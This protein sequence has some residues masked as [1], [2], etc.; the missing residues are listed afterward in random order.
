MRL[1]EVTLTENFEWS[2]EGD[3]LIY[4]LGVEMELTPYEE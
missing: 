4:D 3:Q 2:S 1:H